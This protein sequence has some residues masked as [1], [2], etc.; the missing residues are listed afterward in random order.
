MIGQL[1]IALAIAVSWTVARLSVSIHPWRVP[2]LRERLQAGAYLSRLFIGPAKLLD[3]V[4]PWSISACCSRKLLLDDLLKALCKGFLQRWIKLLNLFQNMLKCVN[5]Q[6]F[7]AFGYFFCACC[8]PLPPCII[9][10][11]KKGTADPWF[12]GP[13]PMVY[14]L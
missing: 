14:F 7:L 10:Q 6:S 11:A 5:H 8:W 3:T 2:I 12:S 1:P 4:F 13:V 9:A